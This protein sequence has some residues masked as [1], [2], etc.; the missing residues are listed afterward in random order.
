[1]EGNLKG[2]KVCRNSPSVSHLM[3]VDDILVACRASM[4]NIEA[5]NR[6]FGLYCAWSGQEINS[7]KSQLLFSLKT[8]PQCKHSILRLMGFKEVTAGTI[9]LGNQLVFGRNKSKEFGRLRDRLQN[10]MEGWK[11]HLLSRASNSHQICD[12]SYPSI[13]HVNLQNSRSCL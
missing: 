12:S 2:I 5:I 9:Y 13:C 7:E 10:K 8:K 3:Y 11:N 1:M 4:E 6:C